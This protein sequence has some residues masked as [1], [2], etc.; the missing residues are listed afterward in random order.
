[1]PISGSAKYEVKDLE[2]VQRTDDKLA[3]YQLPRG[4]NSSPILDLYLQSTGSLDVRFIASDGDGESTVIFRIQA[5]SKFDRILWIAGIGLLALLLLVAAAL[6][7][8]HLL[9]PRFQNVS[10]AVSIASSD[11]T[12][13]PPKEYISLDMY[14][15]KSV[16]LLTLLMLFRLPPQN[17]LSAGIADN[18]RICPDRRALASISFGRRAAKGRI[19]I[20]GEDVHGRSCAVNNGQCKISTGKFASSGAV[21]LIF[22]REDARGWRN[23]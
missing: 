22:E 20:D 10:V 3:K 5:S 12:S 23:S 18:I 14:G 17:F 13:F 4:E 2:P 7:A 19:R 6:T 9:T 21:V 1:M 16:S 11:G 15:K 8:R